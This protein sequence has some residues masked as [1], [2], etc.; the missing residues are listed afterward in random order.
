MISPAFHA[1]GSANSFGARCC[2]SLQK[3][4]IHHPVQK[5]NSTHRIDSPLDAQVELPTQIDQAL[6]SDDTTQST[7]TARDPDD[8]G[9]VEADVATKVTDIEGLPELASG[10]LDGDGDCEAMLLPVLLTES[11]NMA[12]EILPLGDNVPVDVELADAD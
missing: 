3:P 8:V 6:H 2:H 1:C 11:S 9:L 5:N 12:E 4:Y 10:K 7:L